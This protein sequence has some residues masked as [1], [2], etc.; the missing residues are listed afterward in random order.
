MKIRILIS[1]IILSLLCFIPCLVVA[2]QISFGTR[3]NGTITILSS[4]ISL[5]SSGTVVSAVSGKRIKVFANKL[6]TSAT[7][8]VAW[9]NGYTALEGPQTLSAAGGF[10]EVV[11]PPA[12]LF[13]TSTG[14]SLRLL[15]T[16]ASCTAG[17]RVSYWSDDTF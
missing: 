2:D 9:A 10:V 3:D 13:S 15:I 7:C 12:F 17:G 4:T 6:V 16:G 11:S 14:T 1:A 5:T 8:S